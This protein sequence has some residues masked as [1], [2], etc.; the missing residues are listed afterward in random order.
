MEAA[1]LSITGIHS[2]K[3]NCFCCWALQGQLKCFILLS[4]CSALSCPLSNLQKRKKS[5]LL[6]SIKDKY[7]LGM[8]HLSISRLNYDSVFK[9]CKA[10]YGDKHQ[11]FGTL[12]ADE[13][14]WDQMVSEISEMLG[15]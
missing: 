6:Y 7:L 8:C 2:P 5:P 1:G 15:K 11:V 14:I 4:L 9:N 13:T 3:I 12:S 10:E